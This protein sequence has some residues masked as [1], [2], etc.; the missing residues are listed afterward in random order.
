MIYIFVCTTEEEFRNTDRGTGRN[1]T[2]DHELS[3]YLAGKTHPKGEKHDPLAQPSNSKLQP[4]SR[5]RLCGNADA[6]SE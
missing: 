3:D 1:T 2:N 4:A 5:I 6:H